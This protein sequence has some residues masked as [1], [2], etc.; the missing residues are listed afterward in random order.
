MG[1]TRANDSPSMYLEFL[2]QFA[3][4]I[5]DYCGVLSEDSVRQNFTLVYE[6]TDELAVRT[7]Q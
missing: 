3:G 1:T 5:K 6:L 4:V 2:S 7:L